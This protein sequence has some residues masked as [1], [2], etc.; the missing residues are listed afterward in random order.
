MVIARAMFTARSI[1]RARVG[2]GMIITAMMI[3]TPTA[4][5]TSP[6]RA[7]RPTAV[8]K[9]VCEAAVILAPSCSTLDHLAGGK[10]AYKPY[11]YYRHNTLPLE[12]SGIGYWRLPLF[13]KVSRPPPCGARSETSAQRERSEI[14][15]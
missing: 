14:G 4:R 15:Y 7:R 8:G 2:K 3:I 10:Y 5:A 9:A 13:G 12:R 6:Y 11:I 1:S